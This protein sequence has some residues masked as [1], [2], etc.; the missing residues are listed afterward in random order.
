MIQQTVEEITKL[1]TDEPTEKNL[2]LAVD[3]AQRYLEYLDELELNATVDESVTVK[4]EG[5]TI[6]FKNAED[7][8]AWITTLGK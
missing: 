3:A 7:M 6:K 5:H 2:A 8:A 1:A 4:V